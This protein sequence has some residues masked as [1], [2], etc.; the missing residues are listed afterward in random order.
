MRS[1][2]DHASAHVL[3]ILA[4]S[5]DAFDIRGAAL[6]E[7]TASGVEP[8][9][10]LPVQMPS[11]TWPGLDTLPELNNC[12]CTMPMLDASD[13][14]LFG[15]ASLPC[16]EKLPDFDISVGTM[17]S[18]HVCENALPDVS[19]ASSE[20]CGDSCPS[21]SQ[22]ESP[23]TEATIAVGV[24]SDSTPPSQVGV[25]SFGHIAYQRLND[26]GVLQSLARVF[27]KGEIKAGSLCSGL[28]VFAMCLASVG[29]AFAPLGVSFVHEVMCEIDSKKRDILLT[30]YPN[31]RHLYADV[32]DLAKGPSWDYVRKE[33]NDCEPEVIAV[34]FSCKD[35][36]CLPRQNVSF[37]RCPSA[38][39]L[40]S[41]KS[42][43]TFHSA[44][45][46][47]RRW[48]C[49]L[50][51]MENV[52]GLS[53]KRGVDGWKPIDVVDEAFRLAG[54]CGSHRIFNTASY[55][56]PQRRWRAY[57]VYYRI[58]LG[59]AEAALQTAWHLRS[60]A[61]PLEDM[62][63]QLRKR[64]VPPVI[65]SAPRRKTKAV[66]R[67]WRQIRS[68]FVNKHLITSSTLAWAERAVSETC[69]F[70]CL[71]ERAADVLIVRYAYSKQCHGI[72]PTTQQVIMQID[73]SHHRVPVCVGRIPC[74]CPTGLYWVSKSEASLPGILSARLLAAAQGVGDE[75]LTYFRLHH[76]P[77]T[78]LQDCIG[79]AFSGTVCMSV[80]LGA[81]A[82]WRR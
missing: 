81:L 53:V 17:P 73:Q 13:E 23:G 39:R 15:V 72:D 66:H 24:R 7:L 2:I 44:M 3:P 78:L 25:L 59:D 47:I 14:S 26:L 10:E 1:M 30:S 37:C 19:A 5:D 63:L 68:D 18:S 77:D 71:T 51:V 49:A 54:Y 4:N 46:C 45:E 11:N 33:M 80:L 34:G 70:A 29:I 6:P 20:M 52:K 43:L 48:R 16:L 64:G 69:G 82:A 74:I 41:T 56:L 65:T 50:V 21:D 75:E 38:K 61:C 32:A 79:N 9:P 60:D 36:S 8:S 12:H 31:V 35:L 22:S 57:L 55:S 40:K 62:L 27:C 76:V 42:A 67:R 58:G 28:D